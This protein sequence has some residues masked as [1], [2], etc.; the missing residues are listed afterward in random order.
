VYFALMIFAKDRIYSLIVMAL[1]VFTSCQS[2]TDSTKIKS[3]TLNRQDT[4]V[5]VANANQGLLGVD[6]GIL[7]V[8]ISRPA[9]QLLGFWQQMPIT[10]IKDAIKTNAPLIVNRIVKDKY[11]MEGGLTVLYKALP[12]KGSLDVFVGIPVGKPNQKQTVELSDGFVLEKIDAGQ[13][14][15][16]TVNA[17][18]GATLNQWQNFARWCLGQGIFASM[19]ELTQGQ[20][21]FEY[22]LD[23]RNAEMTT[24]VSQATLMMKKP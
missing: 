14:I 13:Y 19:D 9:T 2:G 16:A 11:K 5:R 3:D 20:Q 15:K 12:T 7:V 23:S 17:E 6:T 10:G 8:E 18:P 24:T 22:F 1:I 4:A 21:Y